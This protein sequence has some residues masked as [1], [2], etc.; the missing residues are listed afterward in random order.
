V[1]R[2]LARPLLGLASWYLDDSIPVKKLHGWMRREVKRLSVSQHLSQTSLADVY[3]ADLLV[4]QGELVAEWPNLNIPEIRPDQIPEAELLLWMNQRKG[5]V[6]GQGRLAQASGR[7]L[8]AL[9]ELTDRPDVNEFV[10]RCLEAL[11]R[12]IEV[13][14]RD[15]LRQVESFGGGAPDPEM[16]RLDVAILLSR[17]A[18]Q[19]RD[20]RILNSA[21]KL[22]DWSF[23]ASKRPEYRA[24]LLLSLAQQETAAKELLGTCA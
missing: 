11:L 6:L 21:L 3:E 13:K 9:L 7:N 8:G 10:R 4:R 5:H 22:N 2:L 19:R 1:K 24:R 17:A 14:R 23:G 12:H 20:V 16:E 15:A 18:I